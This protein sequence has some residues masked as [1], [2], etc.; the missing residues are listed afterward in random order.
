MLENKAHQIN[1]N[2]SQFNDYNKIIQD[3][4]KNLKEIE[5]IRKDPENYIAEYFG[6]LTRQIDLRRETLIEEI[7]KYSDELIQKIEKLKQDC[8]AKS[9]EATKTTVELDNIKAKINNLNSTFSS[10][11]IDDIKL[12]EIMSQKKS[13][14]V[15]DLMGL[16][17]NQ[18][19]FELQGKK[20]Y[21][22][23]TNEIKLKDF[24][25]SLSVF[26]NKKVNI[27]LLK[28]KRQL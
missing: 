19:K 2:F 18:Y 16:A 5:A 12:D 23:L 9:K 3:L 24:F 20:Y 28:L 14:E 26:N 17:L 8:V 1:L 11:E 27:I 25:G 15:S 4:N 22:L 13:K 21:K 7:H 6:E 10:L